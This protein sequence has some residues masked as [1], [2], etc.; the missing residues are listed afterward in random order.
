MRLIGRDLF[1]EINCSAIAMLSITHLAYKAM[2]S[3]AEDIIRKL[4]E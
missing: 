2:G 1:D 3:E 4:L